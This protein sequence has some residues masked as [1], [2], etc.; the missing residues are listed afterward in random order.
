MVVDK[1][2]LDDNDQLIIIRLRLCADPTKGG[3]SKILGT[4][5][6]TLLVVQGWVLQASTAE[7]RKSLLD[8]GTK[9]PHAVQLHLLPP[10]LKKKKKMMLGRMIPYYS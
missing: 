7:G 10:P 9:I 8:R 3:K 5:T 6:G 1:E 4:E 2:S